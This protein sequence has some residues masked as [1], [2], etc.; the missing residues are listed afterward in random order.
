MGNVSA[1]PTAGKLVSIYFVPGAIGAKGD[2]ALGAYYP[3]IDM[4]MANPVL[5]IDHVNL[6]DTTVLHYAPL[7]IVYTD[8]ANV[9]G[10]YRVT[11]SR[12]IRLGNATKALSLL[13][14]TYQAAGNIKR[15]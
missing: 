4:R 5:C 1:P 2:I 6:T 3:D 11:N 10:T 9:A 15:D 12:T 8:G 13:K 7:N 14:M